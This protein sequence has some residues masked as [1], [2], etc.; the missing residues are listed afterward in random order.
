MASF[1]AAVLRGVGGAG[2]TAAGGVPAC[3]Q[4]GCTSG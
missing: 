2:V 4:S 1:D 3:E